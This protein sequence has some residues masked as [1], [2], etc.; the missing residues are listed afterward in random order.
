MP[1]FS[2]GTFALGALFL[3]ALWLFVA[4][5]I[6]Y[7][8]QQ[9]WH[10]GASAAQNETQSGSP[11]PA[12]P[13]SDT[14]QD[15]EKANKQQITVFETFFHW[16]RTFFE[17][18]LTDVLIVFFT[19]VLAVKTGGLGSRLRI[20]LAIRLQ[21]T[22]FLAMRRSAAQLREMQLS[23][24]GVPIIPSL[25]PLLNER[26]QVRTLRLNC[27]WRLRHNTGMTE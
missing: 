5:P 19:A 23:R 22:P 16:V 20:R 11:A 1:K 17:I 6:L 15:H 26:Y 24:G 14:K 3:F 4:L 13:K 7:A 27:M 12:A 21:P 10:G 25:I 9:Q 2:E 18:K 8:P